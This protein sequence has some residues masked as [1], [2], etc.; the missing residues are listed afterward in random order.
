MFKI[1]GPQLP[2]TSQFKFSLEYDAVDTYTDSLDDVLEP[3]SQPI[4]QET[5]PILNLIFSSVP[6]HVHS[7]PFLATTLYVPQMV[8]IPALPTNT[9]TSVAPVLSKNPLYEFAHRK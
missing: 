6:V 2:N 8:I 7:T 4:T 1:L 5:D 9:Q 3:Q